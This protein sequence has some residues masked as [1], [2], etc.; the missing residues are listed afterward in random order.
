MGGPMPGM[1]PMGQ[2]QPM[3]PMGG[4]PIQAPPQWGSGQQSGFSMGAPR[5]RRFGDYLETTLGRFSQSSPPVAADSM[6]QMNVFTGQMPMQGSMQRPVQGMKRGGLAGLDV[7][8]PRRATIKGQDHMLAYITPAEARMLKA[9]GGWGGPGPRGIPSYPG[10][11]AAEGGFGL[12]VGDAFGGGVSSAGGGSGGSSASPGEGPG[13]SAVGGMGDFGGRD[14]GP[15]FDAFG[16]EYGSPAQAA[17]ADAIAEA[18]ATAANVGLGQSGLGGYGAAAAAETAAALGG[19][20]GW[21]SGPSAQTSVSQPSLSIMDQMQA[22]A[23]ATAP[24]DISM[25]D[26]MTMSQLAPTSLQSINATS[27]ITSPPD[28]APSYSISDQVAQ[29][30]AQ[31]MLSQAAAQNV[32]D[33]G[34]QVDVDA[35]MN[36]GGLQS[37]N[38]G[39]GIPGG[40]VSSANLGLGN[41]STTGVPGGSGSVSTNAAGSISPAQASGIV[42]AIGTPSIGTGS[43]V[44]ANE[45]A[46][47]QMATSDM[48]SAED[49][50][51]SQP[52]DTPNVNAYA[53]APVA[54][55]SSDMAVDMMALSDVS[56]TSVAASSPSVTT[57]RNIDSDM[58][59]G[60]TPGLPGLSIAEYGLTP[61]DSVS[62]TAPS[63][64]APSAGNLA[65]AQQVISDTLDSFGMLS[66]KAINDIANEFGVPQS[67]VAAMANL[68]ES[69][70]VPA[71]TVSSQGI[72]AAP[73]APS[74][75]SQST[76][77]AMTDE[78]DPNSAINQDRAQ[79][80]SAA[81]QQS[82][83]KNDLFDQIS[84]AMENLDPDPT[85][86]EQIVGGILS[87][88]TYGLIT[89][90]TLAKGRVDAA[91][92][93]LDGYKSGQDMGD[94]GVPDFGGDQAGEGPDRSCP[95]G[96]VLDPATNQ[97]VLIGSTSA[98]AAGAGAGDAAASTDGVGSINVPMRPVESFEDVMARISG[99]APTIAPLGQ[100][101][102]MQAGGAVGLNRAADSFL[103]ALAG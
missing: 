41:M 81:A 103:K 9:G 94:Y 49:V 68:A 8:A 85:T 58:S 64:T 62:V 57:G 17:V 33:I 71:T 50:A 73:A 99:G 14:D 38:F 53:N 23:P 1:G 87:G 80:K 29:A 55:I 100:P 89:P 20:G 13:A 69:Y 43:N 63:T 102:R 24:A 27:S 3:P 86:G 44:A 101:L 6:N 21:G 11:A 67:D 83:T 61:S 65:A 31:D 75:P 35:A 51:M 47:A 95:P 15:G 26:P 97:C 45:A 90:D 22:I 72:A 70:G 36:R 10:N 18:A 12:G 98:D 16:N 37:G 93:A 25:T 5:R 66:G 34:T 84:T 40:T 91:Q 78:N 59:I 96:Y 30:V 2:P 76:A 79:Y 74:A 60:Y 46:A 92:S 88:F 39:P 4:S 54:D 56:P 48:I 82:S 77:P 19:L 52:V 42:S 28:M 7:E 32:S